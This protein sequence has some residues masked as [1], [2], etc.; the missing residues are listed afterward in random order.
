MYGAYS[1]LTVTIGSPTPEGYP[2]TLRGPGGDARGL[3]VHPGVDP[4]YAGLA[5]RLAHFEVGE[6]EIAALGV[7]LFRA[8]FH[9][10]LKE[11]YARSMAALPAAH[12]LR[13][14]LDIDPREAEV[15]AL[16]WEFLRDPDGAVLALHASPLMRYLPQPSAVPVLKAA[17]PLRV[18]LSA[19]ATPPPAAVEREL[20]GVRRALERLGSLVEI[21]VEPHLSAAVLQDRLRQGFHIWHF[22]GHGTTLPDGMG[23][24]IL[25][26][27]T[28]DAAP[29][30]AP[31]LAALLGGSGVR[32]AVL[33]ACEGAALAGDPL[34]ALAP[35]LLAAGV[36]AVVAMQ[37]AVAE[38]SARA[39]AAEFY[40]AL[41]EGFPIDACVTEG[42]RAVLALSGPAHP[43]W[44]VPAL[45]SRTPDGMVFDLPALPKPPCPYP[46]M[47]PFASSD[48]RNFHGR[49][50]EIERTL[51]LLRVQNRLLVIGP[52]GSGK[53]SLL[54]AG[55][56]PRLQDSTL[57]RAN[58]WLVREFRPGPQPAAR[59][60]QALGADPHSPAETALDRAPQL[61]DDLLAAHPP[62][63]RLLLLIDQFEELFTVAERDEQLRFVS[64]FQKLR[65]VERCT[66]LIAMRADFYPDLMN[67]ALW[68]IDPSQRLEV[69]PLRGEALRAAIERPAAAAG[70]RVESGLVDR[71]L[72]DAA[73]EPGA[74]PL[75][76]E[77]LV[78]LWDR[79]PHRML[80]LRAY[81]ELGGDG[82]SGLAVAIAT[83][84]DATIASL[85]DPQRLVARRVLLRLVQFG[86]GR[87]DTRRQQ[88]LESLRVPGE[89]QARFDAT[90]RRLVDDRLL[91]TSSV[92]RVA[93]RPEPQLPP[94]RVPAS[95]R[96]IA[97]NAG[98]RADADALL[99]LLLETPA[100]SPQRAV[101]YETPRGPTQF[102]QVDIS[103]EALLRGWPVIQE[104]IATRRETE[105]ARRRLE[106]KAADW[107]RLERG[108]GLLDEVELAEAERWLESSDA[109]DLGGGSRELHDLVQAS[110]ESLQ[111]AERAR[112]D[113]RQRELAQAQQVAATNQRIAQRTRR[114]AVVVAAVAIIAVAA[115]IWGFVSSER[116]RKQEAVANESARVSRAGELAAQAR[117]ELETL[118]QRSL[119]VAVEA[120]STTMRAGEPPVLAAEEALYLAAGETGGRPLVTGDAKGAFGVAATREGRRLAFFDGTSIRVWEAAGELD[121]PLVLEAN[122]NGVP[123]LGFS[124][125]GNRLVA[126]DGSVLFV[127]TLST[128]DP[129]GGRATMDWQGIGTAQIL[130]SDDGG[131][132]AAAT[133]QQNVRV[134]DADTGA[135][136]A[137]SATAMAALS[138]DGRWL[139][140]A[141]QQGVQLWDL[142]TEGQPR[143]LPEAGRLAAFSRDGRRLATSRAEGADVLLWDISDVA[144]A[145][146][147]RTL[148]APDTAD[149]EQAVGSPVS[150][151]FSPDGRVVALFPNDRVVLWDAASGDAASLV[152]NN[153]QEE[154]AFSPDG[155]LLV[156]S[157]GVQTIAVWDLSLTPPVLR[158]S[159][160]GHTARI[161][162]YNFAQDGRW[163][164][165]GS[166]DRTAR[167]W[168]LAASEPSTAQ[169]VLRGH[170]ERI[171]EVVLSPDGAAALTAGDGDGVRAWVLEP[172]GSS[173]PQYA[174][175]SG[176][177]H[178]LTWF[179]GE[180]T[181]ARRVE[182]PPTQAS[183]RFPGVPV[184]A[185]SPDGDWLVS[186]DEG[187][188]IE[189]W[190]LAGQPEKQGVVQGLSSID[191]AA[192]PARV[193]LGLG[194]RLL[195]IAAADD[196]QV[197]VWSLD[198]DPPRV[199]TSVPN[200]VVQMLDF[201]ADGS[202]VVH[203]GAEGGR[204]VEVWNV[205]SDPPQRRLQHHNAHMVAPSS[206]GRWI[207]FVDLGQSR[208]VFLLQRLGDGATD[209][210][211]LGRRMLDESL[212]KMV[213][214]HDGSMLLTVDA[215]AARLWYPDQAVD[216]T[217]PSVLLPREVFERAGENGVNLAFAP[218]GRALRAVA[219][220][221]IIES[222]LLKVDD[223]IPVVCRTAGRNLT[224]AEWNQLYPG[225]AYRET[226]P[227]LPP[228]P[229]VIDALL[230]EAF[231]LVNAGKAEA[232]MALV[233]QAQ[234]R[235]PTY[236][237]SAWNW[238][239]L[240]RAG[241]LHGGVRIVFEACG[242]AATQAP[243]DTIAR[244]A[245]GMARALMR[246]YG[247]A[248]ED[249]EFI[250]AATQKYPGIDQTRYQHWIAELRAG[251]NP[252]DENTLDSMREPLQQ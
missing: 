244:E 47:V 106:D 72:A 156:A 133:Q 195:A 237:V 152:L 250:V 15:A 82:R 108:G 110:R 81:D 228:H 239:R 23:A 234:Q 215:D 40:Q 164:I 154:F 90:L 230:D 169:S 34:R 129:A 236:R 166:E 188:A 229:S 78:L 224:N 96:A 62:A 1:H 157:D 240:C 130:V 207:A 127:W 201:L 17:L 176:G 115:A 235:S 161:T 190:S 66:L 128:P 222:W 196:Q 77:A 175:V 2:V 181:Q 146:L 68:P 213:F 202:L 65:H 103:H 160:Q 27:G 3:F 107:M 6:A 191:D 149:A 140:D 59:L 79:M 137:I 221:G 194:G 134:W 10:A 165:T 162:T 241:V 211:T 233:E 35:A 43:D 46:G 61:I 11:A 99:A 44:G 159:L 109:L 178:W 180:A 97:A 170:D 246:D 91:T 248:I 245:R 5:E 24:L 150:V 218:D 76:Q 9:G 226:C 223:L 102:V 252:F 163:L 123:Q 217:V 155:R 132:V 153:F 242:Q 185:F 214:S 251:R 39:F 38:E 22:V 124:Q 143:T 121:T 141:G 173:A 42:R 225:E 71:I 73:G 57:F 186:M 14:L 138:P 147:L 172:A 50:A 177:G 200:S 205:T 117:G 49:E 74:L 83:R 198:S 101:F 20:A 86:E 13:V 112:E 30:T 210:S 238:E 88:P 204:V 92:E 87:A 120:I 171:T 192:S 58:T 148:A 67:S 136:R 116:A 26:D 179:D 31:A 16:P 174:T 45:Y 54:R 184:L 203:S 189:L 232:G 139:V 119:L 55:L 7:V 193:A 118:P 231:Q 94:A 51:Q 209:Q 249:F 113:V 199:H 126:I 84:A 183:L 89:D 135:T 70:V 53:S 206:D 85:D 182:W 167:V 4:L 208:P 220:S 243:Q 63:T 48:A 60:A 33:N 104:W 144:G 216:G 131:R 114:F 8:L 227:E 247:G 64:V 75:I 36:P 28:G 29:L 219:A 69:A 122:F 197:T 187:G 93:R 21:E 145:A 142:A 19:A 168:D 95:A 25:D 80:P 32:L 41:A 52:S 111:Q 105:Q 158:H 56:L 98:A 37:F 212:S 151:S 12:G 100:V 125:N 18:L